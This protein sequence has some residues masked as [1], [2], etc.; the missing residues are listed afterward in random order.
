[1]APFIPL[2]ILF[3]AV[4]YFSLEWSAVA[5]GDR[6]IGWCV[7]YVII[8]AVVTVSTIVKIWNLSEQYE[9]KVHLR[10][11]PKEDKAARRLEG[12]LDR[13]GGKGQEPVFPEGHEHL[14]IYDESYEVAVNGHPVMV[15]IYGT[16][17]GL[18][19]F[20]GPTPREDE[21]WFDGFVEELD[22]VFDECKRGT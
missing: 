20:V 8:T 10:Y 2:V 15:E 6:D 3:D 22:G 9:R 17:D 12:F 4:V 19:V 5:E 18:E 11:P 21:E 14:L 7:L 13:Y 16:G 1:M